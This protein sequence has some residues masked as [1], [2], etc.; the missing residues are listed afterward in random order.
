[1]DRWIGAVQ[2][3]EVVSGICSIFGKDERAEDL[4]KTVVMG[5]EASMADQTYRSIIARPMKSYL[6]SAAKRKS[7]LGQE[8]SLRGE[9]LCNACITTILICWALCNLA[10]APAWY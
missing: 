8:G 3:A 2:D 5:A 10:K 1:M 4:Y 6:D 9:R 7:S